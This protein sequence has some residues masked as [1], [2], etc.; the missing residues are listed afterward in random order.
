[1]QKRDLAPLSGVLFVVILAVGFLLGGDSP[2]SSA[3]AQKVIAYYGG[4]ETKQIVTSLVVALSTLPLLFFSAALRERA[5]TVLGERS[6]LPG[7]AF[8]AGVV[9][10]GGFL[11]AATINFALADSADDIAPSAIQALN[12]ISADFFLPFVVGVAALVLAG[13]LMAI[14]ARLV[15]AWL[16]WVGIALVVAAFTPAGFVAFI[17]SGIWIIVASIL[18]SRRAETAEGVRVPGGPAV[19]QAAQG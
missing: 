10:A 14:R 8:G 17:L 11:A 7:F 12:A 1:M 2:S 19:P 16:G 5:R 4:H 13:S 9:A 18:L 15:P 3:S 6:A